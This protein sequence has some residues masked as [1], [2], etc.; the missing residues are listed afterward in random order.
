MTSSVLFFLLPTN[1]TPSHCLFIQSRLLSPSN[2]HSSPSTSTGSGRRRSLWRPS[3]A[4]GPSA[5]TI[6]DKA[7]HPTPTAI[8][9][10]SGNS[11]LVCATGSCC[12]SVSCLPAPFWYVPS[13]CS[14][15]GPPA[16]SWVLYTGQ[17]NICVCVCVF[18]TDLCRCSVRWWNNV[19]A[20][21]LLPTFD[22]CN[23]LLDW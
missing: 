17:R 21:S 4:C 3:R 18:L 15:H 9:S 1:L 16:S 2:T 12:P 19:P 23:I 10:C 14:T 7:Y 11:M 22:T 20:H 8:L 5:A 6:A 13:S